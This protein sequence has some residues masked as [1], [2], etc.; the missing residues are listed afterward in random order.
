VAHG[1]SSQTGLTQPASA[2]SLARTLGFTIHFLWRAVDF[3]NSPPIAASLI[4][5]AGLLLGALLVHR[6]TLWRDRRTQ[7]VA[8]N[9]KFRSTVL[10]VSGLVPGPE[11]H[12]DKTVLPVLL[13]IA[14]DVEKAAAELKP[15]LGAKGLLLER[16]VKTFTTLCRETIPK[17]TSA[18]ELLYGAGPG[19]ASDAR[20]QYYVNV[21]ALVSVASEA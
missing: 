11:H 5:L 8:A 16:R 13:V 15:H 9:A 1:A 21:Q 10:V 12:W 14:N 17:A 3:L 18:A 7:R 20:K 4:G 6:L 2:G 19:A